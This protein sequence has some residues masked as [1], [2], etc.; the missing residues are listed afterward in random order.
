MTGTQGNIVTFTKS[1]SS[2]GFGIEKWGQSTPERSWY[3]GVREPR[4][5][6]G[7]HA[8]TCGIVLFMR[9]GTRDRPTGGS[10]DTIVDHHGKSSRGR[11]ADG[12]RDNF[13]ESV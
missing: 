13:P 6:S 10:G 12:S 1:M 5:T 4:L 3:K 2:S 8:S 7:R 11:G 9:G